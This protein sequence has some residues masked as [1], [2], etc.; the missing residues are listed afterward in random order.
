MIGC[1]FPQILEFKKFVINAQKE[2]GFKFNQIGNM[3]RA[4]VT[5]HISVN[6]FFFSLPFFFISHLKLVI[7][8]FFF[9]C[10]LYQDSADEYMAKMEAYYKYIE[11]EISQDDPSR[12]RSIYERAITFGCLDAELWLQ[13]TRYLVSSLPQRGL[14]YFP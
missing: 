12:I 3:A 10:F 8:F 7:F 5:F 4:A 1:T 9:F 11:Y 2:T 13:Y 6:F 14:M